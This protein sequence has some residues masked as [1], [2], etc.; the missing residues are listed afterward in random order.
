MYA[1]DKVILGVS[2]I[3]DHLAQ[4]TAHLPSGMSVSDQG[5]EDAIMRAALSYHYGIDKGSRKE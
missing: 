5:V 1:L 4:A 2:V 3:D